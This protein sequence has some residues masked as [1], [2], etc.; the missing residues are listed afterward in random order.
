MK[1]CAK[2]FELKSE[3][4]FFKDNSSKTGFSSYCKLCIKERYNLKNP[5]IINNDLSNQEWVPI[6]NYEDLYH[7]SNF[8]LVKSLEKIVYCKWGNKKILRERILKNSEKINDYVNVTLSKNGKI[9]RIPV[10]RLIAV[11]FIP[12]P[13][14]KPFVNHI[15][16]IKNDNRIENLEWC[17]ASE[18]MIHAFKT[19]LQIPL[20]GTDLK[21]SKLT[22]K[23]VLEIRKI[24]KS[25][26]LKNLAFKYKVSIDTISCIILRKTWK[27]I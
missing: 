23:Q 26:K 16:G 13:E 9:K 15:N 18:N 10:H 27:H 19:K 4:F 24:G 20:K 21:H 8:G 17:T 3:E 12:N 11:A 25:E 1:K 14:K 22:E 5:I 7:V 6:L 2:C